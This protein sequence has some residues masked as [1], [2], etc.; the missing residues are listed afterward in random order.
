MSSA[1]GRLHWI[2]A[3]GTLIGCGGLAISGGGGGG[4]DSGRLDSSVDAGP[5]N[6]G[7]G[8]A[9]FDGEVVGDGE[10]DGEAPP[11][12]CTGCTLVAMAED[13][14]GIALDPDNIYWTQGTNTGKVPN[15]GTG[16]V[17]TAARPGGG[18]ATAAASGLTGPIIIAY[19]N[20]YI[21]WSAYSGT[22]D[23][24]GMSSVSLLS[25][26]AMGTPTVP[27]MA[28]NNAYGVALDSTNIYWV[29]SDLTGDALVQSS[30]Q[31]GGGANILGTTTGGTFT[32]LGMAVSTNYIYFVATT[33]GGGGGLFQMA[34]TGGTPS[35]VWTGDSTAFPVG[36]AIDTSMT[37]VYWTD[38][39]VGAVY[40]MP[41]GGGTV[42]TMATGIGGPLQVAADSTNVYFNAYDGN[43]VYEEPIGST[44]P[45]MLVAVT[46]PI[47]VAAD[48]NDS[49]VY[50][51][52]GTQVLSHPK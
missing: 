48:N 1:Y 28:Q 33:L 9:D 15:T 26:P 10:T 7:R 44:T 8:D 11:T 5:G 17:M 20:S 27:G 40:A 38:M 12:I 21:G 30:L 2:A 23:T 41:V 19:A 47:T 34:I 43:I 32:P 14:Q 16:S 3:V 6:E 49:N 39:G 37:N 13:P 18:A 50:F 31:S 51:S 46:G 52:T 24:P 45:K 29:S 36:V 35:E 42:T 4:A 25:V 22:M